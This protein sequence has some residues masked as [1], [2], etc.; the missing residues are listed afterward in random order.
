MS[1]VVSAAALKAMFSVDSDDILITLITIKADASIGITSDIVFA[2]N[3]T[4]R[5]TSGVYGI[6]NSIAGSSV[7]YPFVNNSS[8][9]E[10]TS[11]EDVIYGVTSSVSGSIVQYPFIPVELSLPNDDN[12][13]AAR[14]S[15]TIHDVTRIVLP[16]LRSITGAPSV[17]LKLVL[18]STPNV[19]EASYVGFKLSNVSYNANT[20]TAELNMPSL[21]VEPFPAHSFTPAYFPGLF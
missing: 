12:S 2:D 4:N 14:C 17:E 16:S 21:E 5:L 10:V 9:I 1:R 6:T 15:M 8:T 20:I 19:L 7:A 3:Y 11:D 18:S 13:S